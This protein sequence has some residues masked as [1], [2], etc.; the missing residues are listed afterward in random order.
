MKFT[1][2]FSTAFLASI[3]F[4]NGAPVKAAAPASLEVKLGKEPGVDLFARGNMLMKDVKLDTG[5]QVK[6]ARGLMVSLLVF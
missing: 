4:V 2:I 3:S 5:L 6:G 1:L